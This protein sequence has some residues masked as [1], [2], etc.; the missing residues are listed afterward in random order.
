MDRGQERSPR[1]SNTKMGKFEEEQEG[2]KINAPKWGQVR[3]QQTQWGRNTHREGGLT[4]EEAPDLLDEKPHV[5]DI[6]FHLQA[7]GA[8][9]GLQALGV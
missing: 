8:H 2:D 6:F 3:G 7:A 4:R 5:P 9:L 1:S